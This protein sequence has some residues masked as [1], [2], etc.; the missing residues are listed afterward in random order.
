MTYVAHTLPA[1]SSPSYCCVEP[2]RLRSPLECRRRNASARNHVK[3]KSK[4]DFQMELPARTLGR[5]SQDGLLDTS[6]KV[7]VGID[8]PLVI[9]RALDL[10]FQFEVEDDAW[11]GAA[12]V[13]DAVRLFQIS[14]VNLGIVFDFA[15]LD[16]AAV[17][18]LVRTELATVSHQVQS[19][20]G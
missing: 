13:L 18:L 2:R 3:T 19:C 14:P 5:R 8:F 15:S 7:A 9:D 20:P 16:Q 17:D 10:G 1:A 11:V 6:S 12:E 4:R